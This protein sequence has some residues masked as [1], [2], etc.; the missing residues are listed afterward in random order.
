MNEKITPVEEVLID[1]LS[2]NQL[3]LEGLE[4]IMLVD[5]DNPQLGW[6]MRPQFERDP[7]D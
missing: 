1:S 4:R 5:P 3:A 7:E 2:P 6:K